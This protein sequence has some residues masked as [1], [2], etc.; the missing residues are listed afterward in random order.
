VTKLPRKISILVTAGPT[1]EK[2]DPI[3]FISN[4]STGTFGYEIAKLAKRRGHRVSLISG[5]VSL[6]VPR[7]VRLMRVENALEMR[8]AVKK[9]FPKA[10]CLIM[11]AA[12]SDWRAGKIS[13][14]K[15]KRGEARRT[16]SLMEN[17]DILCELGRHKKKG[18]I[19]VGFALETK[20]LARNALRKLKAKNLDLII[21]N[22]QPKN[23]EIFGD[24]Y[25]DILIIDSQG[26]RSGYRR[27]SKQAL[28]KIILDK[29]LKIGI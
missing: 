23:R 24:K 12:V 17:P 9:E 15:I 29:V 25:I 21:A 20:D 11:A 18:K 26:N 1:R 7:G 2:I 13:R 22:L 14:N 5:P 3:R 4:Y 16:L 28:A 6:A 27:K 8:Q 10:D 19:L